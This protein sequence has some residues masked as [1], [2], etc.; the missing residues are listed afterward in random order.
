MRAAADRI[1]DV[2]SQLA[3]QPLDGE[4]IKSVQLVSRLAAEMGLQIGVQPSKV[5]FV[6][7]ERHRV[8]EIG[9]QYHHCMDG[10]ADKGRRV[11]VD[12]VVVPGLVRVGDGKRNLEVQ[13]L[14]SPCEI[15][16]DGGG[17]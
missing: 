14:L 12:L 3:G 10:D 15:Y 1:V 9:K 7:P 8:V 5:F 16:P 11:A 4:T 2:L 17:A 13:V 6:C